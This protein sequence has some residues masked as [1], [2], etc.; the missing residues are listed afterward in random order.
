MSNEQE[1]A[2]EESLAENQESTSEQESV[3][4]SRAVQERA[5]TKPRAAFADEGMEKKRQLARVIY[6]SSNHNFKKPEDIFFVIQVAESMNI[7]LGM[8]LSG[9]YSV[10]GRL[11]AHSELPV[12]LIYRSGLLEEYDEY[13]IDAEYNRISLENKN[14]DAEPFAGICTMTRKG[15]GS[16]TEFFTV[17]DARTAGLLNNPKRETY[18]KYLRR[19]LISKAR[20]HCGQYLFADIVCGVNDHEV[21][22]RDVTDSEKK[23]L[24]NAFRELTK[25]DTE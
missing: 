2:A 3:N 14:L 10:N 21:S 5:E 25:G 8:A 23:E 13:V 4:Q 20:M 17:E 16:R 12:G 11:R 15:L 9:M 18:R 24:N 6:N 19:M 22:S 7:P 1:W